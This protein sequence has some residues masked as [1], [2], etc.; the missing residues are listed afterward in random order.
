MG[1]VTA[2]HEGGDTEHNAIYGALVTFSFWCSV[3]LNANILKELTLKVGSM[4]DE[5]K[6]CTLV[7]D[8]MKIKKFLEYSKYLDVV[9]GYED[10]GTKRCS[11]S[12]YDFFN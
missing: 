10:L 2:C 12:S 5:E 3:L 8:E 4:S 7:F 9:E 6:Y 1:V 11:N